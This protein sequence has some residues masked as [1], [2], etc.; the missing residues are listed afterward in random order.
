MF[1]I[2]M[3]PEPK[4]PHRWIPAVIRVLGVAFVVLAVL[5]SV[6]TLQS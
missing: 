4:K 1:E 2:V 6:R 3:L 5:V